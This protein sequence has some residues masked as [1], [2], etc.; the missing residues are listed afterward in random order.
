[1]FRGVI[2]AINFNEEVIRN[3]ITRFARSLRHYKYEHGKCGPDTFDCCGYVW[4][5][6]NQV[7]GINIFNVEKENK[8]YTGTGKVWKGRYGTLTE[9]IKDDPI[10]YKLSHIKPG[11][12]LFF[13]RQSLDDT[14][15]KVDNKY[16]GHCGIYLE[17]YRFIHCV[18]GKTMMVIIS[19]FINSPK[20]Q[21]KL[22]ASKDMISNNKIKK[23]NI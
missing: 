11:D 4:Y 22:V 1:M 3:E 17:D 18:S 9:Y 13:H 5:I 15:P 7:M 20:W 2:K 10:D 23:K 16:P 19:D 12:I 8:E 14:E 21:T 6:Y